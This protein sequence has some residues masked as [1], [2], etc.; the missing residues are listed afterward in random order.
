MQGKRTSCLVIPFLLG[1]SVC[2]CQLGAASAYPTRGYA[3][4]EQP[5]PAQIFAETLPCIRI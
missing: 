4:L 1:A 3:G 5:R 2:S